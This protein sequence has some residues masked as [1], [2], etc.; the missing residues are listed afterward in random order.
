[1][2]THMIRVLKSNNMLVNGLFRLVWDQRFHC[3]EQLDSELY[4][5]V[6]MS[7][8]FDHLKGTRA[9][10]RC[11]TTSVCFRLMTKR[12]PCFCDFSFNSNGCVDLGIGKTLCSDNFAIK[13]SI[14]NLNHSIFVSIF[15]NELVG[16]MPT[17]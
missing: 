11:T 9:P 1:M 8:M 14:Q 16:G 13:Y 4:A 7:L 6:R 3:N 2:M 15:A 17:F 12:A 5:C 10:K